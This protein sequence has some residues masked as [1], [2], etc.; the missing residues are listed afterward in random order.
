MTP[1]YD[2]AGITIY[3]GDCREIL[4]LVHA[5]V[6][7]TDPPYG[8]RYV[9]N[10]RAEKHLPIH[11]DNVLPLDV[12]GLLQVRDG[13]AVYWFCR[14]GDIGA[15]NS[16]AFELGWNVRRALCWDKG[17]WASGDLEGD[18]GAQ[19]ETIAWAAVGRHL[20]RGSRPGNLLRCARVSSAAHPTAKPEPLIEKIISVSS[21]EGQMVLDPYMGSGT[22]LVAAKKLGRKAIGIEIEERYCEIAAKRLAQE[23]LDFGPPTPEPEQVGLLADL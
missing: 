7:V 8:V 19:Y 21:D 4:P 13:G 14:E 2:H 16:A 15:F 20:L 17:A 5:D 6:V 10:W 11:G 12:L 1:Y 23:V 22:A 18:W 9:S 3:H